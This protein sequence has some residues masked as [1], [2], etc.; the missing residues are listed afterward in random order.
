MPA[1]VRQ[2]SRNTAIHNGIRASQRAG[3]GAGSDEFGPRA[4]GGR[5]RRA[6]PPEYTPKSVDGPPINHLTRGSR[7]IY[8]EPY[9]DED[10]G[11]TVTEPEGGRRRRRLSAYNTAQDTQDGSNWRSTHTSVKRR[12]RESLGGETHD[13]EAEEAP[14]YSSRK[15]VLRM[16][17]RPGR[18]EEKYIDSDPDDVF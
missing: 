10:R 17:N 2:I 4:T 6:T 1:F 13:N 8:F 5:L 14:C 9:S 16:A 12:E 18:L 15:G 3:V 7:S 11:D